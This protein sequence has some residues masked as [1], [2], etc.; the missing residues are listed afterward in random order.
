[1]AEGMTPSPSSHSISHRPNQHPASGFSYESALVR[2]LTSHNGSGSISSKV[3]TEGV[4]MNR[5]KT[6]SAAFVKTVKEP[7][8]YGDGRGGYGLS[9]LVKDASTG[10]LSKSWAQRLRID[11]KPANVGLG[12]Y[13]VVSLAEARAKAL[14]NRRAVEQGRD[15][16][17]PESS[18][19]TFED[20]SD[21]VIQ[22]HAAAWRNGGKSEAQWRASL[23]EYVFPRIGRKRVDAIT[24]NDVM[25]VLMPVWNSKRETARRVRQRIGAVMKWAVAQGFREDNPAG[26]A[27]GAALPK[28]GVHRKHQRALPHAEVPAALKTIQDSG[29][30]LSTRQAFMFLTLTATRSGEVR[31]ARWEEIDLE[32]RTWTIPGDRTKTGR[33]HR[34][35]LSDPAMQVLVTARPM[36]D[37][38]GLIFPSPSGKPLSDSTMS[39]LV[40]ENGI[41]CVPHGM[42]SSFRDW[43]GESG[44][45]REV[46]E[47]C[48]AHTVKGVEGA[49]FRSDLFNQRRELMEAWAAYILP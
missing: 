4:A 27:I 30:Y 29:A 43:A 48:L 19:P 1:M 35:P 13:P 5:P 24:T 41:E 23:A 20:A 7:G 46:A 2:L 33:E 32:G 9:L 21:V 3:I 36:S 42:R 17:N 34:V 25:S 22:L 15:P 6:L 26:D 45:P 47:A 8:R 40:R 38:S 31:G 10:R 18:I 39:K 37:G 44:A 14:E 12:A 16:R 11:G 28:N 49:Y